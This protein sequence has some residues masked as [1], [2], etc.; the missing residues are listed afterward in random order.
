MASKSYII[1]SEGM[2]DDILNAQQEE[3][4]ESLYEDRIF[5]VSEKGAS[6]IV[7]EEDTMALVQEYR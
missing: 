1:S 6:F 2:S 3:I 4:L 7:N 5:I